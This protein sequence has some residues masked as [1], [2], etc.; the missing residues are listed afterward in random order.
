MRFSDTTILDK[1]GKRMA[2]EI[3]LEYDNIKLFTFMDD[4]DTVCNLNLY[5]D[6][7]HYNQQ[8]TDSIIDA[9]ALGSNRLTKENYEDYLNFLYEFYGNYD[10]EA[11]FAE[12]VETESESL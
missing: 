4:T 2:I 1:G 8:V 6:S 5:K 9:M 10:Y 11:I 12:T 7:L 3:L